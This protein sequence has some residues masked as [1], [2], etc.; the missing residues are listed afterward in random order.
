MSLNLSTIEIDQF[1]SDAHIEFQSEGFKL[2]KAV[3]VKT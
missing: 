1:L 2:E 3:R